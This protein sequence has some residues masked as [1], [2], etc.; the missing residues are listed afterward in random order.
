MT[1]ATGL[2]WRPA[3]PSEEQAFAAMRTA[4][5][6]GCNYWNAAEFYG[7]PEFNSMTL[8]QKYYARYPEDAERVVLNV[9][10]AIF[11]PGLTPDGSPAGVRKS[12]ENSLRMLGDRGK[13][14]I[15]ECGV[16]WRL[17]PCTPFLVLF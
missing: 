3:I 6:A 2:T 12:V 14:D 10:G 5:E 1:W 11:P 16:C 8:L 9:K 17:H 13:I 15:F 7:T 4:L